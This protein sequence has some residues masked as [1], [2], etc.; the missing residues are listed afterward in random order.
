MKGKK[1]RLSSLPYLKRK[2]QTSHWIL[3]PATDRTEYKTAKF[4]LIFSTRPGSTANF[5]YSATGEN[6]FLLSTIDQPEQKTISE[7]SFITTRI[8]VEFLRKNYSM[9]LTFQ[10]MNK[11]HG[12]SVKIF[13]YYLIIYFYFILEAIKRGIPKESW[14]L[15]VTPSEKR[16]WIVLC[17]VPVPKRVT[18]TEQMFH[19][20]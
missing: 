17:C 12:T 6:L 8:Q 18:N 11:D 5:C 7:G 1:R 4:S 14:K 15:L 13:M 3:M 9:Q 20:K 2:G 19:T 10:N 16:F